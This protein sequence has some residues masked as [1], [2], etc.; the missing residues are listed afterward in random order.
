MMI[1]QQII[2][3]L[4]KDEYQSEEFK[5][6]AYHYYAT[7]MMNTNNSLVITEPFYNST[8]RSF[9]NLNRDNLAIYKTAVAKNANLK[10]SFPHITIILD[11]ENS[12][13]GCKPMR[14]CCINFSSYFKSL[15]TK[16]H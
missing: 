14:S 6:N 10:C 3:E 2:D 13:N 9:S 7:R 8:V 16:Y 5:D 11:S 12:N 4:Q 1:S 15:S